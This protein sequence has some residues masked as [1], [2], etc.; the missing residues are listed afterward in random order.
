MQKKDGR[1]HKSSNS[2]R[3]SE[4][5]I[6]HR[7]GFPDLNEEKVEKDGSNIMDEKV[8]GVVTNWLKFTYFVVDCQG[9]VGKESLWAVAVYFAHIGEIDNGVISQD[10]EEVV[11]LKG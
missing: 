4:I 1:R 11:V 9:Q 2:P 3:E 5:Y 8:E 6:L 10:M 7:R